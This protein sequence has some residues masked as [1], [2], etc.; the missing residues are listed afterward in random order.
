MVRRHDFN[1]NQKAI[2]GG[3]TD[4][5]TWT[6]SEI[7]SERV[8]QH[9]VALTGGSTLGDLSRIRVSANG[10]DLFNFTP[11][12]LRAYW[13]AFTWGQ[14]L[15]A[16]TDTAFSIPYAMLDAAT[17]DAA[18][19][20]QF[21]ALSQVQIDLTFAA[22]AVAGSAIMG[23]TETTIEP[24]LYPR[25][26]SSSMN[27]GASVALQ[28]FPFQET[29]IIRGLAVPTVGVQRLRYVLRNEE[30][31]QL[32]GP[33]FLGGAWGSLLNEADAI[34][35]TGVTAGLQS[36]WFS[37][38]NA[39]REASV[40]GSYVELQTGAGWGGTTNEITVYAIVPNLVQPA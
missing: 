14:V 39:N 7:A 12:Q 2:T 10:Q 30:Y 27:I 32:P 40:N 20:C 21:P 34:Y 5:L 31:L 1:G 38:I 3:V 17:A 9:I 8:V 13:Q 19:I 28:R 22:T 37:R 24:Q 29:G 11:A 36:P 26:L 25:I 18:D 33:N 6:A 35:Y 15:P 23:W 16:L 4:T